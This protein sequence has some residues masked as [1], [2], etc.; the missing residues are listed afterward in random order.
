[1][2]E[3]DVVVS[4]LQAAR[5]RPDR[6]PVLVSFSDITAQRVI[7]QR[8]AHQAAHDALTG[9]PNRAHVVETMRALQRGQ[10]AS[11]LCSSSILTI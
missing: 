11:P 1:M 6:S 2:A 5:P 7:A 4:D 8:L 10:A 3:R 9:L